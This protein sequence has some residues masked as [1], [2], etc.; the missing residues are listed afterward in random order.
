[1][2]DK[3]KFELKDV[4]NSYAKYINESEEILSN[5]TQAKVQITKIEALKE[6]IKRE[7]QLF[8][9]LNLQ[10][11]QLNLESKDEFSLVVEA[12]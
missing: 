12:T 11:R 6:E 5:S 8:R 1:M 10:T 9:Q 3:Q 7:K 4:I 2:L